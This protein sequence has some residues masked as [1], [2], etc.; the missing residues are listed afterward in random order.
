MPRGGPARRDRRRRHDPLPRAGQ[1]QVRD[2]QQGQQRSDRRRHAEPA[3]RR[4]HTDF[5]FDPQVIWDPT[6]DRFYY[7]A[8][9]VLSPS[10]NQVAFG[11]STK[12]S[13]S[14][15][16]NWCKY[17]VDYGV[18][19]PDYPKLGDSGF[20][21]MI[22]VNVFANGGNGG[23]LRSD[24]MAISKPPSGRGCPAAS[25]FRF[26]DRTL[27][28]NAFTPVPANEIDTN[29]TGWA[30]A[31][32]NRLPSTQLSLFQ[33]NQN[34]ATGNPV[35]HRNPTNVT[36]PSY[37]FPPNAPQA[38]SINRRHRLRAEHAGGGRDRSQTRRQVRALDAAHGEGWRRSRG[39][40][41]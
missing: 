36:V 22:G 35:I 9:D 23:Y 33:V 24:L 31:I 20:F 34:G 3:R 37:T 5:V 16:A 39:P 10:H 26:D 25:S 32:S 4:R 21:A 17:V 19:F 40:L 41:V 1:Q 29:P 13:P 2:L 8:V 18:Q 38:G 28:F 12:A 11:F 6:T 15:A 7:A 14:N 30:V 27:S